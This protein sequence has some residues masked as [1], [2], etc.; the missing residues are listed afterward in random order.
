MNPIK[1]I[2]KYY[3]PKSK[4]YYLLT[5][6]SKAVTK[7]ALE[8]AKNSKLKLDLKFIEEATMLH[9]IGIFLTKK[10][11]ID[12]HGNKPYICHGYLGRK[13]LEKEGYPKHALVCERHISLT[14]EIIMKES[15][16]IPR[17]DMIPIT[18]EEQ[19]ISFAD[20]FFSKNKEYLTKEKPLNTIKKELKKYK[21][22]KIK[23]LNK[24]IKKFN[25]L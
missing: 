6:H 2:E 7:K 8:I 18:N 5:E 23:L 20:K 11:E 9:D 3:S 15:F 1:I 22:D 24:W 13:L 4:V 17:R 25:Y 14:K 12:C 21:E 16:P 10:P 19:I